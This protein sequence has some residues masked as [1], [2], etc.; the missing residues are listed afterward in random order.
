[1]ARYE[2]IGGNQLSGE[3]TVSGA[4]NAALAIL[5][6]AILVAGKCR[7]EN[8]PDISDVRILLDILADIGVEI[9]YLEPGVVLL[10]STNIK[11]TNPDPALVCKM[12]ASY[13]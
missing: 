3:I 8:V 10:D 7:V 11:K 6:A 1:M 2:I 12:R 13:Y 5:P 9:T 4:K